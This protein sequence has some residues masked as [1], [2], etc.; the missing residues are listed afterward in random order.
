MSTKDVS[1]K[2]NLNGEGHSIMQQDSGTQE[3]SHHESTTNNSDM[4]FTAEEE[5]LF[6]TRYT[7]G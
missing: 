1:S 6:N 4:S 2:N 5:V 3:S 7:E